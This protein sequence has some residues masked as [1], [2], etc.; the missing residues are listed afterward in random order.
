MS[1]YPDNMGDDSHLDS[2]ET[3]NKLSCGCYE[4]ACECPKCDNCGEILVDDEECC[5]DEEE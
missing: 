2:D 3:G 4:E 5:E 1:N